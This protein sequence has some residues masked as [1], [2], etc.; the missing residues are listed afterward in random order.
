M[1][2]TGVTRSVELPTLT[3]FP[4]HAHYQALNVACVLRTPARALVLRIEPRYTR[5]SPLP[6]FHPQPRA[7][8]TPARAGANASARLRF[9]ARSARLQTFAC[10]SQYPTALAKPLRAMPFPRPPVAHFSG[11]MTQVPAST[12]KAHARPFGAR[13]RL[14]SERPPLCP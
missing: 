10:E 6:G 8:L 3:L 9:A 5:V 13:L 7:R 14:R 4:C 1:W 12:V 11:R 2:Q